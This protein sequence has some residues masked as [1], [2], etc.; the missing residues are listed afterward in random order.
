MLGHQSFAPVAGSDTYSTLSLLS[1]SGRLP[2]T[3]IQE[4]AKKVLARSAGLVI[5]WI[6]NDAEKVTTYKK[7]TQIEID[8]AVLP[9]QVVFDCILDVDL[10]Q[11]MLRNANI[12]GM[13]KDAELVDDRWIHENILRVGQTVD[14]K[15]R[16]IAQKVADALA[17]HTI[18]QYVKMATEPAP[19]PP[20]SEQPQGG[21]PGAQGGL[22]PVQMGELPMNEQPQGMPGEMGLPPGTMPGAMA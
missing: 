14:M 7:R 17:A 16:I 10:P 15:R 1:Q 13:L 6:K 3:P 22:P 19:P 21:Q 20:G 18:G 4:A 9:A 12:A 8:P 5:R 2:L 11:D